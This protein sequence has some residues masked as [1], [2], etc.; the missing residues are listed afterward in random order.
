MELRPLPERS[1]PPAYPAR[2][3]DRLGLGGRLRRLAAAA[4]SAAVLLGAGCSALDDEEIIWDTPGIMPAPYYFACGESGPEEHTDAM[5]PVGT[6][7][8]WTCGAET[9]WGRLEVSQPSLSEVELSASGEGVTAL[10]IDPGGDPMA[11]LSPERP[12]L[13]VAFEPGSWTVA[14]DPLDPD[15]AGSFS[16]RFE[17]VDE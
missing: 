8:G 13:T 7:D 14:V 15:E 11:A 17:R 4:G 10:L 9:A 16:L 12:M 3:K 5:G 6:F 1:E 2:S